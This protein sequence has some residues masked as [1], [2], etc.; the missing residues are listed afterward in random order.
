MTERR[1]KHWGWGYEDIRLLPL[2]DEAGRGWD[3]GAARV[4]GEV[5]APVPLE[6]V[7]LRKRRG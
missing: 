2:R 6:R 5:E 7:E 3:S 1:L 4:W